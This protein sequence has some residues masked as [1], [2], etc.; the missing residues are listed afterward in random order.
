M[1]GGWVATNRH[2]PAFMSDKRVEV[3]AIVDKDLDKARAVAQRFGIPQ[4]YGNLPA[5][6]R[7]QVDAV[8]ICTPP[9]LH[10]PMIQ[11]ALEAGKHVLV[12]KPMTLKSTEGRFLEQMAQQKNLILCPCHN[13]LFS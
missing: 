4:A 10:A 11:S 6:W 8:S 1:G 9:W 3:Q 13:F 2:I 12:E 7:G 5:L